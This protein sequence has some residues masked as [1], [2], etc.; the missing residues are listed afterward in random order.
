METI[1]IFRIILAY[2]LNLKDPNKNMKLA[3]LTIYYTFKN[4]NLAYNNNKF[5]ISAPF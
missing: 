3:N 2:K 4:I 5:K 1:L